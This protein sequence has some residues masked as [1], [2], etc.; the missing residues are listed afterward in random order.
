MKLQDN[1][2]FRVPVLLDGS[3]PGL[4]GTYLCN[5][6]VSESCVTTAPIHYSLPLHMYLHCLSAAVWATHSN[7]HGAAVC[8]SAGEEQGAALCAALAQQQQVQLFK[9]LQAN[10]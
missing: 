4:A 10:L 9:H 3:A 8:I 7:S 1:G 2:Y 5:M 6:C